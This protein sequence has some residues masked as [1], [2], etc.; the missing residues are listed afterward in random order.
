MPQ[1][2][3]YPVKS[4]EERIDAL[5]Q[6]IFL[7]YSVTNPNLLIRRFEKIESFTEFDLDKQPVLN[8]YEIILSKIKEKD[9]KIIQDVKLVKLFSVTCNLVW[10]NNALKGYSGSHI[11]FEPLMTLMNKK[12][13]YFYLSLLKL[14]QL[15][16]EFGIDLELQFKH[17]IYSAYNSMIDSHGTGILGSGSNTPLVVKEHTVKVDEVNTMFKELSTSVNEIL[18]HKFSPGYFDVISGLKFSI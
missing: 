4:I 2:K 12:N 11:S 14:H 16:F 3:I 7:Q 15:K 6:E 18:T 10:Y 5:E 17:I 13:R 1:I 8:A 9:F